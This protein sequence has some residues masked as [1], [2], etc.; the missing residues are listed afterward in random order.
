MRN[1]PQIFIFFL[2]VLIVSCR[3][4]SDKSTPV[5]NANEAKEVYLNPVLVFNYEKGILDFQKGNQSYGSSNYITVKID[6]LSKEV[7]NL[8]VIMESDSNWTNKVGVSN[9]STFSSVQLSNFLKELKVDSQDY[10]NEFLYKD[11]LPDFRSYTANELNRMSGIDYYSFYQKEADNSDGHYF[12]GYQKFSNYYRFYIYAGYE[13]YD[14]IDVIHLSLD[15]KKVYEET[16][17]VSGGD[18]GNYCNID[19]KGVSATWIRTEEDLGYQLGDLAAIDYQRVTTTDSYFWE[20]GKLKNRKISKT[21]TKDFP[22]EDYG[23]E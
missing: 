6:N 19:C 10:L 20:S 1:Q 12:L 3:E 15:G 14:K 7:F 5:G 2:C 11:K 8:P 17:W 13:Y 9:D 16:V 21:Y 23:F 18:G 4:K 22:F